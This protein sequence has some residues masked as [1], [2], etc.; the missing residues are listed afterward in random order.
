MDGCDDCSNGTY[1]P[2]NDGDDSDGDGI[3]DLGDNCSDPLANNYLDPAN[4]ECEG[5]PYAP[6]FNGITP[7]TPATT[8][9]SADGAISLDISGTE[10]S[11]LFLFGING[12]PN[13]TISLP[14]ALDT[15]Q[16]GYYTAMVQDSTGCYG[17]DGLSPNGTTLEQPAVALEVIIPFTLCCSGCGINDIDA[18][19]LC[20]DD[21]NCT[22]QTA[23][24]F[25][26]DCNES[27]VYPDGNGDCTGYG[28][29]NSTCQDV[30]LDG[31]TYAVVEIGDLCWF[32]ENL[33]TTTF[34][35]GTAIPEDTDATYS[36][37]P[38]RSVV[39]LAAYGYLYNTATVMSDKNVC[40][41]GWHVST[42]PE[43]QDLIDEAGDNPI[44]LQD[45]SW[46]G[47]T[48]DFG[49]SALPGDCDFG[50]VFPDAAKFQVDNGT[51]VIGAGW[52][53]VMFDNIDMGEIPGEYRSIRCVQD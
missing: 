43:W 36:V 10:P 13:Y 50:G 23:C 37:N 49:F 31:Y 34:N 2:A 15:L 18:D 26:D 20:D 28:D 35:D 1:D 33:R 30:E 45:E 21:D 44:K 38:E 48:N 14:N 5:C 11:T 39:D 16:A 46:A 27:C 42:E 22:D 52:I 9:S 51:S 17:V 53:A 6:L 29:C 25:D 41:T 40:P 24:N 8:M 19:G 3:C 32:A 7:V 12:A 47:G 4:E